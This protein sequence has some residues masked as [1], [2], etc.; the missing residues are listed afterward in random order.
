M[1]WH[2]AGENCIVRS[3]IICRGNPG[4]VVTKGKMAVIDM[5][6]L[7]DDSNFVNMKFFSFLFI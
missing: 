1:Q 7:L 2:G 3:F 4:E 6:L 5:L